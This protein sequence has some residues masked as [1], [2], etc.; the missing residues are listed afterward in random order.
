MRAKGMRLL[1]MWVPDTQAP[2]FAEEA[3]RQSR[4]LRKGQSAREERDVMDWIE[5]VSTM[6]D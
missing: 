2:G 1:Q 4:S 3:R 6:D 5:N